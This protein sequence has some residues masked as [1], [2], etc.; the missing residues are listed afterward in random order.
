MVL[1]TLLPL[2]VLLP[3][4]LVAHSVPRHM[5]YGRSLN[6]A[7]P[8]PWVAHGCFTDKLTARTLSNISYADQR[9]MSIDACTAFCDTRKLAYAGVEYGRE[10]YCGAALSPTGARANTGDCNMPCTGNSAQVCGGGYRLQVYLNAPA[11]PATAPASAGHGGRWNYLGCYTDSVAA[12]TLPNGTH[13]VGTM[14]ADKCASTC[15]SMGFALAGTEYSRECWCGNTLGTAS[16]ANNCDMPCSGN[17]TQICGGGNRLTTST[18]SDFTLQ[19]VF[20]DGAPPVALSVLDVSVHTAILSNC[21]TCAPPYDSLDLINGVFHTVQRKVGAVPGV[22]PAPT[23]GEALTLTYAAHVETFSGSCTMASPAGSALLAA[24]ARHDLWSLCP[25][26]TADGRNDIVWAPRTG[27]P[28]YALR[29]CKP[30][31]LVVEYCEEEEGYE[32][33]EME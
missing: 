27:H 26:T 21:T 31:D 5:H 7:A 20:R 18:S 9:S 14:T 25:N 22:S 10:C 33:D 4:A 24:H 11:I 23:A 28:H 2:V 29:D 17:R 6:T 19:A 15:Q 30:V 32:E 12:R 8:T 13:I 1:N 3:A 16:T